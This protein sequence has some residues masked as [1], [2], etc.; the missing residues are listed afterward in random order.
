MPRPNPVPRAA[1]FAVPQ[2]LMYGMSFPVGGIVAMAIAFMVTMVDNVEHNKRNGIIMA[3]SIGC[4]LAVAVRPELLGKLPAF[5]KEIF[6]S[7]IT[8]GALV[9][10][11]LHLVLPERPVETLEDEDDVPQ[12]FITREPEVA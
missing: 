3:V 8:V 2:P 12:A 9:A 1:I 7:G 4:G 5:V 6:G 10:I 11:T